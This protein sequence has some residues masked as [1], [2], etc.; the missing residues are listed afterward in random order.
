MDATLGQAIG[1]S[2]AGNIV[3]ILLGLVVYLVRQKCRHCRSSCHTGCCDLQVSDETMHCSPDTPSRRQDRSPR[4]ELPVEC[5][6]RLVAAIQKN[7]PGDL[8]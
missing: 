4:L 7:N 3:T 5:S 6:P 1:V 8:L 2:A